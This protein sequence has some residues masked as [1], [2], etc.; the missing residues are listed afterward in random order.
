MNSGT[1]AD[2]EIGIN[3]VNVVKSKR[4]SGEYICCC[5]IDLTQIVLSSQLSFGVSIK[6][7]FSHF[8]FCI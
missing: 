6:S 5:Y 4:P 1:S 7:K 8:R 2:T 3:D